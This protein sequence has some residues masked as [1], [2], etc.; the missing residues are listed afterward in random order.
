MT[1]AHSPVSSR[2]I[3]PFLLDTR[4]IEEDRVIPRDISRLREF[5][6]LPH[7]FQIR[8]GFIL[9]PPRYGS[10]INS[11]DLSELRLGEAENHGS[12]MLHGAHAEQSM[13]RCIIC[14]YAFVYFTYALVHNM[15]TA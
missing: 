9:V 13:P 1:Y 11:S 7:S 10:L 12:Y 2:T 8:E 6:D 5:A 3:I 14:Q 4:S 15:V